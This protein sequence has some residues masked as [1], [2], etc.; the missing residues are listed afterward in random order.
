MKIKLILLASGFGLLSNFAVARIFVNMFIV[1]NTA[2]EITFYP[3]KSLP[4]TPPSGK[5]SPGLTAYTSPYFKWFKSMSTIT[6]P[7][8]SFKYF[9]LANTHNSPG[10]GGNAITFCDDNGG[11]C[12]NA[13]HSFYLYNPKIG[14]ARANPGYIKYTTTTGGI[15]YKEYTSK[16]PSEV[17]SN[18]FIKSNEPEVDYSFDVVID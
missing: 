15:E 4:E 18:V 16:K 8:Y 10:H 17:Y 14:A 2:N 5:Y 9:T 13:K 11:H 12:E 3:G 6:V 7:A 1:N